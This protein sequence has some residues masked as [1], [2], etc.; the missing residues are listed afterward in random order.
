MDN[1]AY[2]QQIAGN[3]NSLANKNKAKGGLPNFLN[4]WVLIGVGVFIALI[5]GVAAIAASLNKTDTKDQ[6]LMVQSY[7]MASFFSEEVLD[8]YVREVKNSDIRNMTASLKSVLTELI[9]NSETI[10]LSQYG[11]DTSDFDEDEDPVPVEEHEKIQKVVDTLEDARLNAM[12][13][14]VYLREVTLQIAY[15]R[16]YQ[17][18]IIART[19]DDVIKDYTTK[20]KANLDNMYDQF[21][22]F[23]SPTL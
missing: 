6:D 3:D 15:L 21:S 17:S 18:E 22:S 19:K 7:W 1:M 13:D 4:K 20:A 5:I 2:L 9:K 16:A 11:I 23:K 12:L 14:R 10:M 8:E